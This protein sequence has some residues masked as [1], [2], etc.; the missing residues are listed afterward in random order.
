MTTQNSTLLVSEVFIN[1][2][3]DAQ[4]GESEPYEPYTDDIGRLFRDF[5]REYGRCESS[6]Y[7]DSKDGPPKRIGWV[8][9]KRMEY[10]D[11]GRYGREREFYT[12]EVWVTLHDAPIEVK[13]THHYHE[14]S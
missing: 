4:F 9:S 3:K 10:E 14:L 2:D 6:V 13:R 7:V 8:F 1:K 5:Q 12:R 11:S